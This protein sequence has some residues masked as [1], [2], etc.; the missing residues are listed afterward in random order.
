MAE[1]VGELFYSITLETRELIEGQRRVQRE[2]DKTS[3]DLGS[4]K[5]KLTEVAFA[6]AAAA[7]AIG[8]MAKSLYDASAA[9]E[10]LKT[11]L[12]FATGGNGTREIEYL[13]ALTN[14]L[15]LEFATT[16]VAY[17]QFQAAAK[18]TA[19][20]G[21]KARDVFES[22]AKSSA[23][24]GLSS[25]QTSGVLLALQQMISKGTV[26]A[27][28]L[29]GQLG[30]RL[31]GA[32]QIAA[33]AMGVT[34]AELGKMLEQGQVVADDFLPKFAAALNENIGN[35]AENAA[36]RLDAS[37]NRISSAWDRLK[38]TVG[39]SGI[40]RFFANEMEAMSQSMTV[41]TEAMENTKKA[42]GGMIAQFASGGGVAAGRAGFELLNGSANLL[43]GT[44]NLLTGNVFKLRTDLA[45]LPDAFKTNA[46]Q[47]AIMGEKIQEAQAKLVR[48]QELDAQPMNGNYYK[49]AIA[50]TSEYIAK[51]KEAQAQKQGLQGGSDPRDIPANMQRGASFARYAAEQKKASDDLM[52]VRQRQSGV[53]KTYI[54]DLNAY[55]NALRLGIISEKEY[56]SSVS[57]L[58]R[59]TYNKSDAGAKTNTKTAVQKFDSEAYL[60]DL[61]K[62]QASEISIINETEAEKLR[63]AKKRRAALELDAV[64]YA[65]AVLLI[66]TAAEQDRVKLMS[67]TQKGIDKDREES[68]RKEKARLEARKQ[69]EK[70]AMDYAAWLTKAVNPIDALRQE[71]QAKLDIVLQY[72]QMMAQAGVD[73]TAQ[74][75]LAR[76]QITNE[77]EL[78]RR[79]LAEQS[80]RSQ[81]EAQA[82]LLDSLNSL[83]SSATSSIVGLLNGTTTAQDA[84][85]G[86]ANTI[87]NEAVG[88]LVQMGIQQLKNAV[89]GDTIAAADKA[90]SAAMG[91]VYAASVS[92]QVQGM[93]A[94][95]AQ[96][97]FAA[98]SAIPVVGPGL[99]PGAAAAAGATA[100]AIGAPAIATASLAGARQYGGP[101]SSGN[102]YRVN[103]TGAPEMFTANNGNQYMLPTKSGS[104]TAADSIGGGGI[105]VK[106]S[107]DAT[108][109][110]V[111]GDNAQ[112]KQ[113]G[114]MLGNVVMAKLIEQ[115]RPGGIL[116]K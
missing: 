25:S 24:M 105:N 98:T 95:A 116:Y 37:V 31:P 86:L 53:N 21:Q 4:L 1:K 48:L 111:E 20:E 64:E 46:Q 2:L 91:A 73:A 104:V 60:S 28:E 70:E 68:D 42:G 112:A 108:G 7:A 33:K 13:R 11:M 23:V 74:G 59:K 57:D 83:S 14:R 58:A 72:E 109:S 78:Q 100:M 32:F 103:E 69:L 62:A 76:T 40:S 30:E 19:L 29:R 26:Q 110:T 115:K 51:L 82:F 107:V 10:R 17:G 16:A 75:Q 12:D 9:G 8:I 18:G 106:V 49:S 56:I 39:N 52:A 114:A 94:M 88:A 35:A 79:A 65:E 6:S 66:Q 38:Q 99:A 61:R 92:A 96:N 41:V 55:Q 90:K 22:V 50:A 15:G 97:A 80:F 27:E 71:Y 101:V 85:R 113:L 81:G 63:I 47:S 43:N 34:T 3:G 87:T 84:I 45:L 77:Y 93:S 54:E 102:M 44:I 67:N 5:T 36:G 89:I